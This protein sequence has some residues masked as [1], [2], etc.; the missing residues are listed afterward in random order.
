MFSNKE[1]THLRYFADAVALAPHKTPQF[2]TTLKKHT[3]DGTVPLLADILN[4]LIEHFHQY[5]VIDHKAVAN[6][7]QHLEQSVDDATRRTGEILLWGLRTR[8]KI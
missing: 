7:G 8:N 3:N 2:I 4:L 1:L 5:D 6:I